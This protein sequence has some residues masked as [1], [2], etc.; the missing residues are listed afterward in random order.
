MFGDKLFK[1]YLPYEHTGQVVQ[2]M[3]TLNVNLCIYAKAAECF[4]AYCVRVHDPSTITP[5]FAE[6]LV[7][8]A[9]QILRCDHTADS[10]AVF[11]RQEDKTTVENRFSFLTMVNNSIHQH[12]HLHPAKTLNNG[13]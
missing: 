8:V 9:Q 3:I 13:A 1:L 12:G 7:P 5:D 6:M 2:Q 11:F 4:L 10:C